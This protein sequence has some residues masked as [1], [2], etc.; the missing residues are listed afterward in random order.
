MERKEPT[1]DGS[2]PQIDIGKTRGPI[3]GQRPAAAAPKGGA[4]QP[5]RPSSPPAKSGGS[6]SFL[7]LVALIVGFGG[8]GGA[9]YLYKQLELS[10]QQLASAEER[11]AGLEKRF[12]M[13]G[14]ESAASVEVLSAKVKENASEVRKLWGIAYDRNRKTI[15]AQG[16][17]IDANKKA[18]ASL[19]KS[20]DG[21]SAGVKKIASLEASVAEIKKAAANIDGN[22]KKV[23]EL[24]DSVAKLDRS[25]KS[26]RTELSVRVSSNEE[27]IDSMDTYRRS[28]NKDIV[29]LK[30]AIRSL[31]TSTA[32]AQ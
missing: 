26:L 4:Q 2:A 7:T 3:G 27:A 22:T 21:M 9:A 25:V 12:E 28:V 8:A 5:T 11:I 31:Q 23:R 14:E 18:L 15:A 20:V 24:N 17:T 32:S 19:K 13:S 1:L 6:F 29:Q 10:N 30:D 16:N